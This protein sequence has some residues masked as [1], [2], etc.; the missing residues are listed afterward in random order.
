MDIDGQDWLRE[1]AAQVLD[2]VVDAIVTINARGRIQS[3]NQA[4]ET[5]FGFS[6][7][8][9]RGEAVEV[10]MPNAVAA[11][12]QGYVDHYLQTGEKRIIGVG[13]ELLARHKSGREFPIYL[14]VS[15]VAGDQYFVGI[16]RDLSEQKRISAALD[17]QRE[18][19][20]Q[21]G[22]VSTM[23]EMT[24]SIAHEINQPLS[25]ISMYAQ[26]LKRMAVRQQQRDP[27]VLDT[28][29]KLT[30]QALRAGEVIER[31]QRFM[32]Q[33][34]GER[35]V[36]DLHDLVA[37]TYR[38]AAGDARLHGVNVE[39]QQDPSPL[40]V[41][42]DPVEIQQV[43]LNLL[44][45]AIDA[46]FEIDCAYGDQVRV[47]TERVVTEQHGA[48]ARVCV[49]DCGTGVPEDF[50]ERLFTPFQSTKKQGMGMGLS[51]CRN[52]IEAH[53]G[54]LGF[55]NNES[56]GATFYFELPLVETDE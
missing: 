10:L 17:E 8:E 37:D 4:T 19:L 38:L 56:A 13:R 42:V 52:I 15:P 30:E 27:K 24:A 41:Q 16:I 26:A 23:G 39:F 32:Q 34:A 31:I 35:Q 25:A 18:Q 45:N 48:I 28:L 49:V 44:R 2:A 22:R 14:A 50:A 5:L 33:T 9:L 29:S 6:A 1:N 54:R 36:C 40:S 20:A 55:R 51:I 7:D 3:C 47:V 12:H 53:A 11:E 21:A 46:M 43:I